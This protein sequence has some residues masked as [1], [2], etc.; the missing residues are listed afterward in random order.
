MKNTSKTCRTGVGHPVVKLYGL[1]G[2]IAAWSPNFVI[3]LEN[4]AMQDFEMERS[5]VMY[6]ENHTIIPQVNLLGG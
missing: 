1:W 5:E 3:K 4:K 2:V 6:S